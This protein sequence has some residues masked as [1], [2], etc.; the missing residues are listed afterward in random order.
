MLELKTPTAFPVFGSSDD[1]F[2]QEVPINDPGVQKINDA[3]I[4]NIKRRYISD[5]ELILVKIY[6][7]THQVFTGNKYVLHL[8]VGETNCVKGDFGKKCKLDVTRPL[9]TCS[10]RVWDLRPYALRMKTDFQ[11]EPTVNYRYEIV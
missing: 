7:A 9:K 1:I 11:C 5:R 4:L 2:A 10:A 8:A 3:T 6:K